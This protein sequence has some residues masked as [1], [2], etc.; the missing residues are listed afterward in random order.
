MERATN[1]MNSYQYSAIIKF[2]GG[3]EVVVFPGYTTFHPTPP[4]T[5]SRDQI[6]PFTTDVIL[7]EDECAEC[8]CD[9]NNRA[10]CTAGTNDTLFGATVTFQGGNVVRTGTLKKS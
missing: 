9:R 8:K 3:R 5:L 1:S 2:G 7:E 4:E 10:T 6:L